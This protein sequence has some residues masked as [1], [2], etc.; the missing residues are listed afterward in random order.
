MDYS[1]IYGGD[2][3]VEDL[4]LLNEFGFEFVI[5]GGQITHV[6]HR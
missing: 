4:Q 1:L 2:V 3:T 5:E 6:L